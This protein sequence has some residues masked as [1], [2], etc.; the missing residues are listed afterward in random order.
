MPLVFK[1][2]PS[3]AASHT[4]NRLIAFLLRL[5]DPESARGI[6]VKAHEPGCAALEEEW[7]RFFHCVSM[8]VHAC[9]CGRVL[10]SVQVNSQFVDQLR[11]GGVTLE[12]VQIRQRCRGTSQ[13]IT[14]THSHVIIVHLKMKRVLKG[15]KAV[16]LTVHVT[17]S[18]YDS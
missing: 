17:E 14:S 10:I 3:A 16:N 13:L 4:H 12:D 9:V 2:Y 1:G 15:S 11:D 18:K 5:A 8:S 7:G 6:W